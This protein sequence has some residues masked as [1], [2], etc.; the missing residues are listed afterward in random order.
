MAAF[1]AI[2]DPVI[3]ALKRKERKK[4]ITNGTPGEVLVH[5]NSQSYMKCHRGCRGDGVELKT[6]ILVLYYKA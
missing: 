5:C 1:F 4:G 3:V 2:V 6:A